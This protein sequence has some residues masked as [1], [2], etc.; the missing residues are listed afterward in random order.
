MTVRYRD[1]ARVHV[2]YHLAEALRWALVWLR[3]GDAPFCSEPAKTAEP[4][5]QVWWWVKGGDA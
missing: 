4:E 1:V 5:P 3:A 2:R